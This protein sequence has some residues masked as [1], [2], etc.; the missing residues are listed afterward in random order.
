MHSETFCHPLLYLVVCFRTTWDKFVYERLTGSYEN[1]TGSVSECCLMKNPNVFVCISLTAESNITNICDQKLKLM[2]RQNNTM[3]L[4]GIM[5]G[6]YLVY[7]TLI[8]Q[9]Y[10]IIPHTTVANCLNDECDSIETQWNHCDWIMSGG[11]STH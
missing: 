4:R 7:S 3:V 11:Y 9:K 2:I 1:V 8:V 10:N 6:R 5:H